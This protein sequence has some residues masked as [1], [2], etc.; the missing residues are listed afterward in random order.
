[1]PANPHNIEAALPPLPPNQ[2]RRTNANGSRR[3]SSVWLHFNELTDVD[4]PIAACK[5][6]HKRYRCD[7]KNHGTSNMLAHSKICQKNPENQR[8]DPRQTNLVCGEGGFLVPQKIQRE[9]V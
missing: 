1:M 9:R 3:T 5:H 4:E 6:C 7:S 2:R 8:N